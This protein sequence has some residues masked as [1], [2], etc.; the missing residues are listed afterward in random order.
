MAEGGSDTSM[1]EVLYIVKCHTGVYSLP[2]YV[3]EIYWQ[4]TGKNPRCAERHD[5][6]LIN[7]VKLYGL[8]KCK[9]SGWGSGKL[10][11]ATLPANF[12]YTIEKKGDD[13]IVHPFIPADYR[14]IT[15]EELL[16]YLDT[17][18]AERKHHYFDVGQISPDKY[19]DNKKNGRYYSTKF[20]CSCPFDFSDPEPSDEDSD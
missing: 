3:A 9:S 2:W 16:K 12:Y 11:I 17:L 14:N 13:E 15:H 10:R 20:K 7:A 1:M 19:R 8:K 4:E 6:D 18:C 5:L